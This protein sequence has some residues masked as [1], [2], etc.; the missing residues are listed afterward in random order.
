VHVLVSLVELSSTLCVGEWNY[1]INSLL[2]KIKVKV[3][4]PVGN[5]IN[6][7][8]NDAVIDFIVLEGVIHST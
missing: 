5:G 3:S 8:L 1:W 2:C 4:M 7:N 6:R